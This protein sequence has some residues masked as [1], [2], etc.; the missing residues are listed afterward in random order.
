MGVYIYLMKNLIVVTLLN[1]EN[2][3]NILCNSAIKTL[4]VFVNELNASNS[5]FHSS[6]KLCASLTISSTF[7]FD[8]SDDNSSNF[9]NNFS[10]FVVKNEFGGTDGCDD[11]YLLC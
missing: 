3:H 8:N 4:C 10:I 11:R 2:K 1:M 6:R 7:G 5:F 9:D